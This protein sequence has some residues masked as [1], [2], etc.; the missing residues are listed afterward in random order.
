[1]SVYR[2]DYIVYGYKMPWSKEV[3]ENLVEDNPSWEY[4]DGGVNNYHLIVDQMG[5]QYIVF[6]KVLYSNDY[7]AN[8]AEN[9]F[10]NFEEIDIG[11]LRYGDLQEHYKEAFGEYPPSSLGERKVFA[12]SHIY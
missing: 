7:Y 1:M 11:S 8:E 5:G 12:F 10:M 3:H 2:C 6:G 9:K 4:F